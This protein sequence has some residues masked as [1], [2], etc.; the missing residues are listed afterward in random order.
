MKA[1]Q[2]PKK[3][4]LLVE[5]HPTTRYGL[6]ALISREP[7]LEVCGEAGTAKAALSLVQK[8]APDLLLADLG[9]PMRSGLDFLKDVR[10]LHPDLPVLVVSMHDEELYAER[11]IR[12][13]ARGYIMKS[14]GGEELLDAIRQVLNGG[15]YASPT[16]ATRL[17][18]PLSG[19]ERIT[20]P[21]NLES[22]TDREF[23]IFQDIGRGLAPKLIGDRLGIS[24]KTV[25]THCSH[26][27][28]KLR[29][30]R[31]VDLVRLALR[32]AAS[33]EAI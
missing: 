2:L 7:E 14:E 21:V 26:I 12:A 25:A 5:D 18:E 8:C 23:E 17:L 11:A 24:A 32:W 31:N 15:I 4:I 33:R 27:R 9:L 10:A 3:R 19:R 1:A 22:L 20:A 28:S 29:L 6:V 30:K 13:G 16:V